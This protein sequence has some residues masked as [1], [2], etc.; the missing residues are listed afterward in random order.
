MD[1]SRRYGVFS[2][3]NGNAKGWTQAGH[4]HRSRPRDCRTVR[5]RQ[6]ARKR[7]GDDAAWC[8]RRTSGIMPEKPLKSVTI[9]RGGTPLLLRIVRLF[10]KAPSGR[11]GGS[12]RA[13][14][15][16]GAV[17]QETCRPRRASARPKGASLPMPARRLSWL[18]I[19][20]RALAVRLFVDG[21]WLRRAHDIA[22]RAGAGRSPFRQIFLC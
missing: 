11:R 6:P 14:L 7:M 3:A 21:V 2:G 10:V 12:V 8:G 9:S 19:F 17:S 22:Q 16:R 20:S 1:G 4:P 18:L 13:F 5:V 15:A